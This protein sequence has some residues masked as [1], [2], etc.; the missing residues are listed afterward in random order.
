M[1]LLWITNSRPDSRSAQA[2]FG[3][4]VEKQDELVFRR[5]YEFTMTLTSPRLRTEQAEQRA[6]QQLA[7]R[8]IRVDLLTKLRQRGIDPNTL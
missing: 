4:G 8:Q 2:D 6:E 7:L 1:T 3:T 5:G